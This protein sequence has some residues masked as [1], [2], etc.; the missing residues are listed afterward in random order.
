MQ[1]VAVDVTQGIREY[2]AG[3]LKHRS[4]RLEESIR[5]V[6]YGREIV[7]ESDLPYAESLDRG[8]KSSNVMWHLINRVVPLKLRDGRTIFRAMTMES[9]R[10]G[11]W[12]TRP[13]MGVDFTGRGIE[14][15][16]SKTSLRSFQNFIVVKP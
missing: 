5:S 14:I 13:R 3:N 15:A 10:R 6:A 16:R 4:G 2:L 11:K 1:R 9:V 8:S 12:R 7:V